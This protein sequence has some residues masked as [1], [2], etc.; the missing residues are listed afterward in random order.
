MTASCSTKG[1]HW[2]AAYCGRGL[3]R[4]DRLLRRMGGSLTAPVTSSDGSRADG[5]RPRRRS[6]FRYEHSSG[7]DAGLMWVSDPGGS[8]KKK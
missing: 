2:A 1:S 3:V 4:E 5:S 6:A 8:M 7:A